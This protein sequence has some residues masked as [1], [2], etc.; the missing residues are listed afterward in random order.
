MTPIEIAKDY[1][2]AVQ[3]GDQ[4]ALGKLMSPDIVWHQPGNNRFS[5]AHRGIAAVG[6]MLGGMHEVSEGTFAITKAN[7][8]MQNGDWVAI[9]LEFAARRGERKVRQSGVDIYRIENGQIIEA[10]LFS[11]DQAEEDA[12]WG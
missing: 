11:G 8:Y 10:M 7:R 9:E 3:T 2:K 5:G 1:I 4:A 6:K 12:F